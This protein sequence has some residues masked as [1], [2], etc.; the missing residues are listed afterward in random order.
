MTSPDTD[1]RTMAAFLLHFS[2]LS[3]PITKPVAGWILAA[4][5]R[6]TALGWN[7]CAHGLSIARPAPP[8][9]SLV[10]GAW[11]R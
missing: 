5:E 11:C 4:A 6:Y 10:S 2:A 9:T 7:R 3:I 1:A 8:L